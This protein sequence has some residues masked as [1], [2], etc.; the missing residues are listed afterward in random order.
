M[1]TNGSADSRQ[2]V[3]AY[4]R[5]WTSLRFEDSIRLLSPNL[6]VEVPINEYPSRDSFA[7]A[8]SNFGRMVERVDLLAELADGDQAMLLYD[9]RV[10][11]I[12]TMRVAE[13]FTVKGGRITLLRQIHDTAA[14]RA[15]GLTQKG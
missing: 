3:Q 5:G 12:G 9:M 15:A 6:K 4:H 14:V 13:H 2:V 11:G 10:K 7:Q 8:L 1:T